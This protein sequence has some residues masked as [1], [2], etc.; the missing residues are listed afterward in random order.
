MARKITHE[1]KKKIASRISK[2]RNKEE[3]VNIFNIIKEEKK[4]NHVTENNNGLFMYFHDLEDSTYEKIEKEIK[5][6]NNKKKRIHSENNGSETNSSEIQEYKPYSQEEF[7]SQSGISA[8]LKFSNKEKNLLKREKY[9]NKM[10]S[11]SD[12]SYR[13]FNPMP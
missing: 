6:I 2:I 4:N 7:P 8:K 1:I 11:D 12:I 3:L 9:N 13:K 10:N 5:R